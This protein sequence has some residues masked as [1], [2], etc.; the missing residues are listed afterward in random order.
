MFLYRYFYNKVFLFQTMYV[1]LLLINGFYGVSQG[2][3][4]KVYY[5]PLPN[6]EIGSD[7]FRILSGLKKKL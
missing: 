2:A 4:L 7:Y 6:T 3:F 5:W 1:H